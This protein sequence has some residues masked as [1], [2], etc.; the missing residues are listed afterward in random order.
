LSIQIP[1]GCS[2]LAWWLTPPPGETSI[3]LFHGT[4]YSNLD[5][6]ASGDGIL[7]KAYLSPS[8]PTAAAYSIF[9]PSG[10]D[11]GIIQQGKPLYMP[12]PSDCVVLHFDVPR[13]YVF[14][15]GFRN[16]QAGIFQSSR[17]HKQRLVSEESFKSF[18]GS[19][20]DYYL[21]TEVHF[22]Q[23]LPSEFLSSYSFPYLPQN[24]GT[25]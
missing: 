14:E 16:H 5:S 7:P 3:R 21:W 10:G 23:G 13:D 19:A 25:G 17:E 20:E 1:P 24:P 22:S 18:A 8:Y 9:G 6:I 15:Y 12:R 11:I 2:C 4:A